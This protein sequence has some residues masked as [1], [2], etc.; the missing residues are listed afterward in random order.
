M[1][2]YRV[3]QIAA[4]ISLKHP[5]V[6]LPDFVND[7]MKGMFTKHM[8]K[9]YCI[10]DYNSFGSVCIMLKL[11]SKRSKSERLEGMQEN[12]ANNELATQY[13]FLV[14]HMKRLRNPLLELRHCH[15]LSAF[16]ANA[17][18][19]FRFVSRNDL[20]GIILEMY[21]KSKENDTVLYSDEMRKTFDAYIRKDTDA[22][23]S[24]I[25]TY[26][27]KE[28]Y[29]TAGDNGDISLS[30]KYMELEEYTY[31]IIN[32]EKDG[33]AYGSLMSR[34]IRDLPLFRIIS[35]TAR[36]DKKLTHLR[37]QGKI[38]VKQAYWRY[39][40]D[41]DQLFTVSN[42]EAKIELSRM[43]MI[44]AGRTKFFGR[45]INPDQF[46]AELKLLETGDIDDLDDQVT[47]IAG[48]VLSDAAMLQGP[49]DGA[50]EFDF[51]VNISN[52]HFRPEQQEV[53][54]RIDFQATSNIFHCKV[55]INESVTLDTVTD[56]K[57]IVPEKEQAVIFTC[58][59]VGPDVLQHTREDRTVQIIDEKGI[60]SWCSITPTIP[61]RRHSVARVMYGEHA[62][63]ILLIKSL[64]YES[65]FAVGEDT[66]GTESTHPIGSLREIELKISVDDDYE[67][68]TTDYFEFLRLLAT[69]APNSFEDAM[70]SR[71]ITMDN[72]Q[73][74]HTRHDGKHHGVQ[75]HQDSMSGYTL[76]RVEFDDG[77]SFKINLRR[78]NRHNPFYCE[79]GHRLN[80]QQYYTLCRHLVAAID[81]ACR[82]G[83]DWPTTKKN[84]EFM[85]I[86]LHLFREGNIQRAIST[87]FEVL[88]PDSEHLFK[89][90]LL[91]RVGA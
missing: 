41:S 34:L 37:D 2:T 71:I 19:D 73:K 63:K 79:C 81:H 69:L 52:Y 7:L 24:A 33:L 4:K 20:Q 84:V 77:T 35:N 54:Q 40:P 38:V 83:P 91:K 26:M 85:R 46:I 31:N 70:Q 22:K 42:Y 12:L 28:S 80:E 64:N 61:C 17:V 10:R 8:I 88:D 18:L 44:K 78:R 50:K 39:S 58:S 55:M 45:T 59:P 23:L 74:E 62:G 66:D 16:V 90:Y 27:R 1:E 32:K 6:F 76:N 51:V 36:L 86:R 29:L 82:K 9:K 25:I 87:I 75:E 30:R 11:N 21:E 14:P 89:K 56:L 15:T 67:R 47:R 65:G 3:I 13:R 48:L 60:R 53:M 68:A 57:K 49:R 43:A 72:I 5:F